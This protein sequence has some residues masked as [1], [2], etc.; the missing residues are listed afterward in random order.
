MARAPGDDVAATTLDETRTLLLRAGEHVCDRAC[1]RGFLGDDEA[2]RVVLWKGAGARDRAPRADSA[3][4]THALAAAPS[5]LG[6]LM[7]S[8]GEALLL[9]PLRSPLRRRLEL[10]RLLLRA[11]EV[12]KL[13]LFDRR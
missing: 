12:L 6:P 9:G 4:K 10:L 1:E 8:R 2:H 7:T 11:L 13:C 3:S 5:G